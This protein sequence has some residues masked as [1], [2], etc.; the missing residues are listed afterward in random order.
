MVVRVFSLF[1][2]FTD[3][4][5]ASLFILRYIKMH[6]ISQIHKLLSLEVA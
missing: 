4:Y 5:F 3:E 2:P 6:H 1:S